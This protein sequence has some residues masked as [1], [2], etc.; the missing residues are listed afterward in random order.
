MT[1]IPNRYDTAP[2][3]SRNTTMKPMSLAGTTRPGTNRPGTSL[4]GT[5][6]PETGN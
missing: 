1:L 5:R 2:V 6:S 4:P 3:A